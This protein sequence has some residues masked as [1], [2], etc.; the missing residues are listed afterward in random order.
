MAEE[1]EMERQYQ[2]RFT[3]EVELATWYNIYSYKIYDSQAVL[4]KQLAIIEVFA[5]SM[6]ELSCLLFTMPACPS[7][8]TMSVER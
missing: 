4:F 2:A 7:Q 6:N 8:A 1:A 3:G 5:D